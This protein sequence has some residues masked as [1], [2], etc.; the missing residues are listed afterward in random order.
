MLTVHV[1][2][3]VLR[4]SLPYSPHQQRAALA[5][6]ETQTCPGCNRQPI[7]HVQASVF[8]CPVPCSPGQHG[9]ALAAEGPRTCARCQRQPLL[10][11]RRCHE[12][13]SHQDWRGTCQRP[14]S[15]TNLRH[16]ALHGTEH[17][18][19]RKQEAPAAGKMSASD[20]LSCLP[21]ICLP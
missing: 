1:S 10:C 19:A 11:A 9:A 12:A 18:S 13:P 4:S 20:C 5:A 17:T 2:A 14:C 15:K 6:Q 8:V 16:I 7:R 3:Q 21:S